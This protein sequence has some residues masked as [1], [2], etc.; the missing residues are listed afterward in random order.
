M[1][2]FQIL[3]SQIR[4]TE[5]PKRNYQT[6]RFGCLHTTLVGVGVVLGNCQTAPVGG[7]VSPTD[8]TGCV[9]LLQEA[10]N[11]DFTDNN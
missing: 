1:L 5:K 4:I 2:H 8:S 3:S 9:Q 10:L 6:K 11:Y 7:A